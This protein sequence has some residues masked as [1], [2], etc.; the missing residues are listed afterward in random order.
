M[1]ETNE[2]KQTIRDVW[3]K[4]RG[5]KEKFYYLAKFE[6]C[7]FY[8]QNH[9][10][11]G[12]EDTVRVTVTATTP[13]MADVIRMAFLNPNRVS[14]YAQ[15]VSYQKVETDKPVVVSQLT[16]SEYESIAEQYEKIMFVPFTGEDMLKDIFYPI[17]EALVTLT[18]QIRMTFRFM[19]ITYDDTRLHQ[20]DDEEFRKNFLHMEKKE[21]CI[22]G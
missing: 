2:E 4:C 1:A 13:V 15:P 20:L 10:D 21:D 19:N 7:V 5:N 22:C 9:P 6:H 8:L 16:P 3:D 11:F 12:L 17:I 14:L 18:Q